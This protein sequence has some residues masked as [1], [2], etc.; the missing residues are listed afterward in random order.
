[1]KFDWT[2]SSLNALDEIKKRMI[3]QYNHKINTRIKVKFTK[4][5]EFLAVP[6]FTFN[7]PAFQLFINDKLYGL[8]LF[9]NNNWKFVD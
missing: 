2:N 5:K 4:K 6:V 7:I 8:Y 3:E 1:M 9:K